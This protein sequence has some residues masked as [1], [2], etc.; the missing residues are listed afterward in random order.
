MKDSTKTENKTIEAR[1]EE[2]ERNVKF[3]NTEEGR[4][5]ILELNRKIVF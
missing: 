1:I 3:T 4:A 2:I 5:L